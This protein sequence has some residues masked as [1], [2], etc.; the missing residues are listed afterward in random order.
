ME[1]LDDLFEYARV[2]GVGQMAG[3]MP[4]E[5][6]EVSRRVLQSFIDEKKV[7]AI[8]HKD[9]KKVIGSLGVEPYKEIFK[10]FD[11]FRGRE[12]GYVLSQSYWGKGL[13]PEAVEAVINYLFNT[14]DYDF[15]TCA[16]F[17]RNTQSKK[18][19]EKCGFVPY[20]RVES[21]TLMGTREETILNIL[22]NPEKDIKL[23]RLHPETLIYKPFVKTPEQMW[24]EYCEE[25][26]ISPE[27]EYDAWEFG[28][29]SNKLAGLVYKGEKK[30]TT[31]AFELYEL[32]N[33]PIPKVGDLSII[34]N[35]DGYAV[36]IIKDTCVEVK[37]FEEVD[38]NFAFL[39]GE[40]DKSLTYWRDVHTEFLKSEL[41]EVSKSFTD[42]TPVVCET[43]EVVFR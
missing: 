32:D 2:D 25:T 17:V 26:G 5:S 4:H 13:M 18:V 22:L 9:D 16:Y 20:R 3:W 6:K 30:A 34:L 39:E 14:L 38:E 11:A 15:I 43:F 8:F 35:Q 7:F 36:C 31:S 10:E 41:S 12:I 40:G 23:E 28:G 24:K 29:P 42:K 33:E 37:R 21:D 27:T 19:Q 1:D